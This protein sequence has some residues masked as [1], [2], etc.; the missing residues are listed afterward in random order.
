M[1]PR[2][3]L[4]R[5]LIRSAFQNNTSSKHDDLIGI[6]QEVDSICAYD[7]SFIPEQPSGSDDLI[8]DMSTDVGVHSAQRIVPRGI[9]PRG[10]SRLAQGRFRAF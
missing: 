4:H 9:C 7:S 3:V 8:E 1:S 10:H 5:F 6:G 2:R